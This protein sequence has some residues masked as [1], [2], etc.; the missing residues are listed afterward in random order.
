MITSVAMLYKGSIVVVPRPGR[1]HDIIEVLA[2]GGE[3]TP[4][5]GEQGFVNENGNFLN[6]KEALCE[7]IRCN[8][9][10]RKTNPK[11]RLFSEDLW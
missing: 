5:V 8:Q 3:P 2:R 10:I 9:L 6:R 1:H 4:V 11:D 7:A